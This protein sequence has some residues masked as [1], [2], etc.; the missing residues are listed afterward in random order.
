MLYDK[1]REKEY[2]LYIGNQPFMAVMRVAEVPANRSK[3]T[4]HEDDF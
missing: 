4:K 2:S 3:Y 1:G